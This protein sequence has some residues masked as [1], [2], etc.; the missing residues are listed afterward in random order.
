MRD[1]DGNLIKWF[2]ANTN[3]DNLKTA[4]GVAERA[5]KAKDDFLAALS[6]E[7]RMPLTPVLIAA[8]ALCEDERLPADARELLGMVERNIS[9]E[10]RLIDDLL[11]LTRIANGKLTLR[12][13]VCD[14]HYLIRLAIEIVRDD[15]RAKGITISSGLLAKNSGLVADPA[16]FQQVIW[17]LIRKCGQIYAARKGKIDNS[18]HWISENSRGTREPSN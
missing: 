8:A 4:Q 17:N 6:H 1:A 9:L 3:I 12:A 16:R 15:A 18:G 2:G 11:D 14:A 7:L 13:Q 5:S 10:A